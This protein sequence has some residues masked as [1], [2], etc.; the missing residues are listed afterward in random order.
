LK[1]IDLK[2]TALFPLCGTAMRSSV[3]HGSFYSLGGRHTGGQGSRGDLYAGGEEGD[4]SEDKCKMHD[5][6]KRKAEGM[7]ERAGAR[8]VGGMGGGLL[9]YPML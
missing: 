2:S 9:L 3:G 4:D 1:R 5:L 6:C 7:E 8:N